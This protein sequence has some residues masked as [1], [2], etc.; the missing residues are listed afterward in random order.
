M[1]AKRQKAVFTF[2]PT[3]SLLERVAEMPA[4][5][6]LPWPSLTGG[7]QSKLGRCVRKAEERGREEGLWLLVPPKASML[8]L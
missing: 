8:Y 7:S 3:L 6:C 4:F 2:H 5:F 1:T